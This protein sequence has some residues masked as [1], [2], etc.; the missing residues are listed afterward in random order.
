MKLGTM[1]T[2]TILLFLL[3]AVHGALVLDGMLSSFFSLC[4]LIS[5]GSKLER[6]FDGI[7]GLSGGG[8][9]SRF[10]SLSCL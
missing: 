7:G 5:L 1:L 8:A 3:S 2:S 9:T 10:D 6:V 4:I